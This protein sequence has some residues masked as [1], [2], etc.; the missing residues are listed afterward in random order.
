MQSC[1]EPFYFTSIDVVQNI[2]TLHGVFEN[3][4]N[5]FVAVVEKDPDQIPDIVGNAGCM[6]IPFENST[7]LIKV[8]I[9]NNDIS[10][11]RWEFSYELPTIIYCILCGMISTKL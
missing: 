4:Q 7:Y 6:V 9:N 10:G 11:N 2:I 8:V 1:V 5:G 3:I